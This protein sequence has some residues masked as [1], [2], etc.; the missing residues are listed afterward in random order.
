MKTIH[1]IFPKIETIEKK[2]I[3]SLKDNKYRAGGGSGTKRGDLSE[4]KS[5]KTPRCKITIDHREKNS[6]VPSYLKKLGFEIELKELKVADYIVKDIAIERKTI[7]DFL[8]SMINRRLIH[9]LE[10]LQQYNR[11]LLVIEGT[12]HQE[13]Y[14]DE[15]KKIN[16]DCIRGF[17]LSITLKHNIPII[18]TKNPEDT[19]KFISVLSNKKERESPLNITK[20]SLNSK[21]QS[22]YIIESFPGIGPKNSKKLLE[23]FKTIK[24]IINAKEDELKKII[25]KKA[26]SI[27]KIRDEFY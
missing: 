19:A 14:S 25:G 1:N 10:E 23:H 9:Q 22:R 11:K 16:S 18:F 5:L 17:L 15:D 20:K 26:E 6:L 13:L 27:I 3:C 12:E 4:N 24:N 21:E 2:E 7:S 8:S